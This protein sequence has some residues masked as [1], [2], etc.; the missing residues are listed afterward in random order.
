M[1]LGRAVLLLK[2]FLCECNEN[3]PVRDRSRAL[4]ILPE[5]EFRE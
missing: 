1:L 2:V 3:R 5:S 4:G